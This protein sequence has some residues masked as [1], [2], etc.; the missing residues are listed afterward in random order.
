MFANQYLNE[1]I[2]AELRTF[3]NTGQHYDYIPK[4]SFYNFVFIDPALSE[5]H[6]SDYTGVVVVAVDHQRLV[7]SPRK[8]MRVSPTRWW[9]W[10]FGSINNLNQCVSALS[11]FA[12]QKAAIIFLGRK[13]MRRKKCY[14]ANQAC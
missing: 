3:K 2:P 1:I 8:T 10:C 11:R 5:A 12:Y 13:Q 14:I 6:T 9:I 4:E 7:Y